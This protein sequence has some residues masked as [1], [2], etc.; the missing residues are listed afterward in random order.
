MIIDKIHVSMYSIQNLFDN[1]LKN[2]IND[3]RI[4]LERTFF[5][6]NIIFCFLIL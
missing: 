4:I 1:I 2:K 5:I 6:K 3:I